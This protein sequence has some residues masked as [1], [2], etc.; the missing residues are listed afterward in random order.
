MT[1][2]Q[3]TLPTTTA[4]KNLCA[5]LWLQL[6]NAVKRTAH[7]HPDPK[8]TSPETKLPPSGMPLSNDVATKLSVR[9]GFTAGPW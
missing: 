8:D 3:E 1:Y 2:F 9:A 6:V 5:R 4:T 7:T